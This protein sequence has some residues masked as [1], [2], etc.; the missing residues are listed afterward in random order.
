MFM[1]SGI[2]VVEDLTKNNLRKL[3]FQEKY[4]R[5][6]VWTVDGKIYVNNDGKK[7]LLA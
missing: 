1:D 2:G 4:G 7:A 6:N 3:E 5:R